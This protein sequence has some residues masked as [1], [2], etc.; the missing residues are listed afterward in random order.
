M[1]KIILSIGLL[2]FMIP[3]WAQLGIGYKFGYSS[4][5]MSEMN[6]FLTDMQSDM[7]KQY[8]IP[9][10]IT[11]NFPSYYSHYVEVTYALNKNEFGL[12]FTS[13]STAGI[14]TYSDYSG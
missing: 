2:F 3:S 1:K 10:M 5:K 7:K 14:S 12:N 6:T 13:L 4:Y 8:P 11:D 9:L